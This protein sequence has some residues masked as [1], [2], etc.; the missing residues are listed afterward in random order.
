MINKKGFTLTEIL[1]AVMIVGVIGIALAALTTA[2]LRES[3]VGRSRLMLRNQISLFLRQLRQD[4]RESTQ[5]TTASGGGLTLSQAN[6]IGG[7]VTLGPNQ[8]ADTSITY[9]CSGTSNC[10]G[11]CTRAGTGVLAHVCSGSTDKWTTYPEF[12]VISDGNVDNVQAVLRVRL[13]VG[14]DSNP[15]IKEAIEETILLPHGVAIT[16]AE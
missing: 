14:M 15:P 13:V 8:K 2:A 11:L 7:Y 5:I 9:S 12:T 1:L 4:V 10:G 3:G 16:T 6:P